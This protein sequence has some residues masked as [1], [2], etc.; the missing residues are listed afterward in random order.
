MHTGEGFVQKTG[1]SFTYN[2]FLKDHLG[3]TRIVFS[4]GTGE[5]LTFEQST[6]YY[7]FGLV[8][9]G[10]FGEGYSKYQYNGKEMQEE[11]SLGWLDYGWRMY[12]PQIGRWHVID[13][14]AEKYFSWSP[15]NYV[16][17]NPV[18]FI[19]PDG[20]YPGVLFYIYEG[21]GAG[22]AFVYD[23]EL[24]LVYEV[25]YP[26]DGNN[27]RTNLENVGLSILQRGEEK[28]QVYV[29]NM[30]DPKDRARFFNLNRKN[31]ETG[32]V[33]KLRYGMVEV[34]DINAAR[35]Y[36]GDTD[37]PW[38]YNLLLRNCKHYA[39]NGLEAGGSRVSLE[40]LGPKPSRWFEDLEEFDYKFWF[41]MADNH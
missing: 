25:N 28:T 13:P 35:S 27:Q 3:N 32:E 6:D 2:Y 22:H 16:L 1:S 14:L 15:Y 7:P 18:R 30:S 8:H 29:Y 40:G 37:T 10:G 4:T 26:N 19:D 20:L 11:F 41:G 34:A 39:I 12:D 9:E 23:P 38:N 5:T 17:N 36:F 21:D 31:P 33:E 24:N